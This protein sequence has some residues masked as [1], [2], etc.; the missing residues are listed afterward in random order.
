MTTSRGPA[1]DILAPGTL[2]RS[3]SRTITET[4]VVNFAGL[5][6][7]YM[8]LHVSEVHAARS[9]YGRRVAHGALV[10][11]ISTGLS[12]QMNLVN[13]IVIAFVGVDHLRFTQPVFVG[14]TLTVTKRVIERREMSAGRGL[15]LFDTKVLNQSGHTV[16]A[17]VDKLLVSWAAGRETAEETS[18]AGA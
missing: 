15:L 11:G 1:F 3:R 2:F 14:D 17:Y 4:D 6:G 9:L 5:S 12:A 13:D 7:D 16:L 18:A 10:F 8:E